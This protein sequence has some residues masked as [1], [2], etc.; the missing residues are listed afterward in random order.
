[1]QKV[2]WNAEAVCVNTNYRG[3]STFLSKLTETGPQFGPKESQTK[4]VLPHDSTI[5]EARWL[6]YLPV[7]P[8]CVQAVLSSGNA[9]DQDKLH[10]SQRPQPDQIHDVCSES[11]KE[12]A[13][14]GRGTKILS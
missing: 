13:A 6:T 1:M 2:G 10:K 12:K 5:T 8:P 4:T 11:Q 3:S 7:E 9:K 14:Q